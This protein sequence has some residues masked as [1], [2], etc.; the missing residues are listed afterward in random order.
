MR[1]TRQALQRRA[2]TLLEL[3]VVLGILALLITL[4][5]PRVVNQLGQS[6]PVVTKTQ[7]QNTVVALEQFR[8]DVGRYP[9]NEEGLQALIDRPQGLEKW[10]GPYLSRRSLPQ[11][12]WGNALRYRTP[13]SEGGFGFEVYSLGADNQEGGEGENAD[14]FSWQ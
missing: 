1:R 5:A 9:T 4:V 14:I 11:D 7:I 10:N 12:G 3:L 13:A 2:F 8:I 6:R